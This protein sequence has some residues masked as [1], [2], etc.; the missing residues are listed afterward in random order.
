[1]TF[2][3]RVE[4]PLSHAPLRFYSARVDVIIVCGVLATL[5]VSVRAAARCLV[6]TGGD[7]GPRRRIRHGV[8]LPLRG[9][10][11]SLLFDTA[12]GVVRLSSA[13]ET[14]FVDRFARITRRDRRNYIRRC[15][16]HEGPD[17][18]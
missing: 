15:T 5:A 13:G 1:M 14:L 3:G 16:T 11:W 12:N 4:V 9:A 7:D 18:A 17:M 6:G 10:P 8:K 2:G